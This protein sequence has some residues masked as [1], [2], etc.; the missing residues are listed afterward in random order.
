MTDN[1]QLVSLTDTSRR[2][3]T[4]KCKELVCVAQSHEGHTDALVAMFETMSPETRRFRFFQSTPVIR[5]EL[6]R[7][8]CAVDQVRHRC[9]LAIEPTGC[10]VGE[11]R[12]V[13]SAH[14]PSDHAELAFA[15]RDDW[16]GNGLALQLITL[17]AKDSVARGISTISCDVM[18]DN[19][20]CISLIGRLGMKLR[21]T[22]GCLN[23]SLPA[24]VLA[25]ACS[26]PPLP[27]AA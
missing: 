9:W 8:M 22:D 2:H 6:V 26:P 27:L 19:R 18:P 12:A 5:R 10:I 13:V 21:F 25:D 11:V 23:G 24:S 16:A 14:G 15:V 17:A 1:L 4:I 3:P 20:R 7:R